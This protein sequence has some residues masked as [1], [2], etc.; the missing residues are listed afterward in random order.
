MPKFFQSEIAAYNGAK[1]KFTNV[2][3][4]KGDFENS[5]A[6]AAGTLLEFIPVHVKNPPVI[7]FIAYIDSLSDSFSPEYSSEQPFGRTDPYYIW[8]GSKRTISVILRTKNLM[9]L[10]QSLPRRCF[11]SGM[12][13]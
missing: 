9:S 13:T 8:K 11:A 12:Q 3:F 5:D 7:Q 10:P 2:K 1:T 4:K 6:A